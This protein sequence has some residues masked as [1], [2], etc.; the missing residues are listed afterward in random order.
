M[1][2]NAVDFSLVTKAGFPTETFSDGQTIFA[3]GDPGNQMYVVRSGTVVI[4][5]GGNTL[6]S[7]GAGGIFGEM[8]LIDQSPRS[9]TAKSQGDCEVAPI[10][11]KA[12]LFLVHETPYFALDVMRVLAERVRQMNSLI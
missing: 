9:A 5:A 2:K 6:T 12:F 4:E 10:N 1:N 8:S 3:E 11:D 7:V